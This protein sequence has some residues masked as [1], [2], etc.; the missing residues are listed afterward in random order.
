[1]ASNAI[2]YIILNP[3]FFGENLSLEAYSKKAFE[4]SEKNILNT[5]SIWSPALNSEI[6]FSKNGLRHTIK[7]KRY[8]SKNDYTHETISVISI[9]HTLIDK[10]E[11]SHKG[12]D[13]Y[14]S[15]NIC[16]II[17]LQSKFLSGD[18]IKEVEFLLKEIYTP[19]GTEIIFYNH[20]IK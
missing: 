8:S 10:A 6:L 17:K 14:G 15:V 3:D 18:K 9:F 7:Q 16:S 5:E 11:I 12:P 4:W 19:G 20:A 2:K 13:R 1:M